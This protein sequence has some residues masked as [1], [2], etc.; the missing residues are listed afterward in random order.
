MAKSIGVHDGGGRI[1]NS[2]GQLNE[3]AVFRQP[4]RWCDYSGRISN[5]EDGF[6]GITLMNHPMNPHN[7]TAFHVRDDGW[8]GCCLSLDT[9][10]EVTREK[11]LRVRYALWVHDGVATQEQSEQHWKLFTEMPVADLWPMKK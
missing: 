10:V 7:P 5:D 9:P 1:L 2:E 4:A 11:K 6:A 3:K 8:M